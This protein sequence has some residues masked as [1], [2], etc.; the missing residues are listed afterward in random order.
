MDRGREREGGGEDVDG[1]RIVVKRKKVHWCI[2][3]QHS[4]KAVLA[5]WPLL[6]LLPYYW[7]ITMLPATSSSSDEQAPQ[8]VIQSYAPGQ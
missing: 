5:K 7:H 3:M 2:A 8:V 1:Y 4:A 6:S